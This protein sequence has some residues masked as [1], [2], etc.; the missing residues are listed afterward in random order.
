M[1]VNGTRSS[2]SSSA[3]SR[4][5]I[6]SGRDLGRL[7]QRHFGERRKERRLFSTGAFFVTFAA[8]R[9]ITHAIR[10]ERG[11]FKNISA[12]GRHIHHMTFGIAGLLLVGYLWMLEIGIAEQGLSSRLTASAYGTGAALTLG[13][14]GRLR[15]AAARAR[16]RGARR[17]GPARCGAARR[18]PAARA[19][20]TWRASRGAA[21]AAARAARQCFARARRVQPHAGAGRRQV[22]VICGQHA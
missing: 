1:S 2:A 13:A 19:R 5:A 3:D 12:G 18:W 4:A 10:A 6:P 14:F 7:Y 16:R 17:A 21:R 20:D 9:A 11:P 8:V 22:A 15:A